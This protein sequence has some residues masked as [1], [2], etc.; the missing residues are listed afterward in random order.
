MYRVYHISLDANNVK[1]IKKCNDVFSH[2]N[3]EKIGVLDSKIIHKPYQMGY[4][5]AKIEIKKNLKSLI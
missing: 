4:D 5:F 1:K 3:I 2:P